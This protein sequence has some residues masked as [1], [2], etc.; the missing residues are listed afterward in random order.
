MNRLRAIHLASIDELRNF[1]ADWDELWRR[2]DVESPLVRAELL[3]EW[4]ERFS[5]RGAFHAVVIADSTR[6]VAAL[7]LVPCRIGWLMPAAG[8]PCNARSACGD[9]LCDSSHPANGEAMNLLVAA[10]ADLPWRM[11]WLGDALPESARWQSL[12]RACAE[13]GA[14]VHCH[15]HYRVGRVPVGGDWVAYQKQLAKNHRQ[16][17][18]RAA[19]RLADQG[20]VR[21]EMF[22]AGGYP[23]V[24]GWLREAFA[25]EDM[26]WKGREGSSV[27]RSPGMFEFYVRQAEQLAAWGHWA[28]AA[29]RLDGHIVAFMH[30]F[31]SKGACFAHKISFDPRFAA[32]SPGQLLFH[33]VLERLHAD[34]DCQALDFLG[35]MTQSH[36]RWRPTTYG[37]G[38]VAIAPRRLLGR[39]AVLAYKNVW[40]RLHDW[41]AA[42]PTCAGAPAAPA[43][44]IFPQP[45]PMPG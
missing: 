4:V 1:A 7:P 44:A 10:A 31:R 17:M 24:E 21:F 36:D 30:G 9:L 42:T 39:V 19:R 34:G 15:E 8:M 23:P 20:D 16:A 27:L 11:L 25:V 5:L 38:R 43:D 41:P 12:L 6:W 40:R 28:P 2:S 32:L 18:N 14:A 37:V 45:V 35:P 26:G 22:G 29:L 3:A 33:H 13:C